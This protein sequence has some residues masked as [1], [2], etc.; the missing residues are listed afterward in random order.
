MNQRFTHL[1]F[2]LT[3][4]LSA[5][6]IVVPLSAYFHHPVWHWEMTLPST[7]QGGIEALAFLLAL[8]A[9]G[10]LPVHRTVRAAGIGVCTA[11]Y[12]R[13]HGV[14]LPFLFALFWLEGMLAAGALLVPGWMRISG[15]ALFSIRFLMGICVWLLGALLMS[16][17]HL[18]FAKYLLAYSALLFVFALLKLRKKPFVVKV[19]EYLTHGDR[20]I[21]ISSAYILL[22]IMVLFAR[23]PSMVDFDSIWYGLRSDWVL[24][25]HGSI[26]DRLGLMSLVFYYPKLYETL[27]LPVSWLDEFDFIYAINIVVYLASGI[28][29]FATARIAGVKTRYAILAMA[30]VMCMP[31]MTTM[32]FTAKPDL[33]AC[34]FL[35]VGSM[36]FAMA[37]V[38]DQLVWLLGV[39]GAVFLGLATKLSAIPF[40][41]LLSLAAVGLLCYKLWSRA[42]TKDRG[43]GPISRTMIALSVLCTIILCAYCL[44]TFILAGYPFYGEGTITKLQSLFGFSPRYPVDVPNPNISGFSSFRFDVLREYFFEPTALEHVGFAWPGDVG[45]FLFISGCLYAVATRL[46]SSW[47][48]VAMGLSPILIV[49]FLLGICFGIVAGGDGNYFIFP[50][51]LAG[52]LGFGLLWQ[53]TG[54]DWLVESIALATMIVTTAGIGFLLSPGAQHPGTSPWSFNLLQ[55]VLHAR[56]TGE[57]GI[58]TD[59]LK[60]IDGYI[61]TQLPKSCRAVAIGE[62]FALYELPC[63]LENITIEKQ[64]IA[65]SSHALVDY[66]NSFHVNFLISPKFPVDTVYYRVAMYLRTLGVPVVETPNYFAVDLRSVEGKIP[67]PPDSP[68][69]TSRD[70]VDLVG[71]ASAANAYDLRSSGESQND[72]YQVNPFAYNMFT[73]VPNLVLRTDAAVR[74]PIKH[75]GLA[76][77]RGFSATIGFTPDDV[78]HGAGPVDFA[79]RMLGSDGKE[80]AVRSWR[81]SGAAYPISFDFAPS[82]KWNVA[83]VELRCTTVG[84]NRGSSAY[85]LVGEP[86]VWF[87]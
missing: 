45:A 15:G 72:L 60:P 81:L 5:A 58:A 83:Y 32:V 10:R 37:I 8:I 21:S 50:V 11:L 44:R 87:K 24:A 46:R 4:A 30:L 84:S 51:T 77:L 35:L 63:T 54:H 59:G 25:P 85:I 64:G 27:I 13:L 86:R 47:V 69:P 74:I 9:V 7:T 49:G 79:V 56:G 40:G 14:D 38:R 80:L 52:L 66:L 65:T 20:V 22:S 73:Y 71:A 28:C 78:L 39:F 55:P 57:A 42:A 1:A 26:F 23:A 18:A 70:T 19:L 34:Y 53:S 43:P 48:W 67:I 33:L 68:L 31:A 41:G 12:L 61:R 2:F 62:W 16:I 17:L 82:A 36:F 29:G 3:L 76:T 75:A 6:F